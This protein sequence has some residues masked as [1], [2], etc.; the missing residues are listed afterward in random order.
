[1]LAY[2]NSSNG[3][4]VIFLVYPKIKRLHLKGGAAENGQWTSRD[5][6]ENYK[7]AM[8]VRCNEELGACV[9][10]NLEESP[11]NNFAQKFFF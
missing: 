5:V 6:Y 4:P 9:D 10:R 8:R 11:K 7:N 3:V 1:M 2:R